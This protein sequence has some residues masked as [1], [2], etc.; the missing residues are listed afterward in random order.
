MSGDLHALPGVEVGENLALG[1][2]DVRGD[3]TDLGIEVD[4]L[5]AQVPLEIVQFLRQFNDGLLEIQGN[6][7]HRNRARGKETPGNAKCNCH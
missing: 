6:D 4:V 7:V 5:P 2:F 1:L 3:A